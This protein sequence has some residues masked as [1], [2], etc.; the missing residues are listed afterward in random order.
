MYFS[1][2]PGAFHYRSRE[3]LREVVM[4]RVSL[5]AGV[6]TIMEGENAGQS[7]HELKVEVA[8]A[9][10]RETVGRL[11]RLDAPHLAGAAREDLMD[12]RPHLEEAIE[13]LEDIE[14][15]RELTDRERE[16][17]HAFNMLLAARRPPG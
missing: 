13:A 15:G 14:R 11:S 3:V 4:G 10:I 7:E 8:E 9:L 1:A 5:L 17:Q 16:L 6:A 12:L 2:R